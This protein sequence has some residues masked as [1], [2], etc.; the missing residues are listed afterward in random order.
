MS[1]ELLDTEFVKSLRHD[2]A[3]LCCAG[4]YVTQPDI[5]PR[6][7][8]WV[9]GT[10]PRV[11][12]V[13]FDDPEHAAEMMESVLRMDRLFM[14]TLLLTGADDKELRDLLEGEK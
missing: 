5:W 9:K 2:L 10:D 4:A 7:L 8:D 14:M 11:A 3:A 1:S 12:D 13:N 6:F